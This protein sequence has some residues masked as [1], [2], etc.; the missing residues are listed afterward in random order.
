MKD[1][2]IWIIIGYFSGSIMFAYLISKI[3]RKEDIRNI[4]DDGN[5]GTANV[6]K[7]VGIPLGIIALILELA[8]GFLPVYFSAKFLDI[9]KLA[10]A[11]VLSAPVLGH[12]FP[13]YFKFKRGGK[14]IA[15]S[16]GA[17][18]GLIPDLQPALM[19]AFF[20]L[21]FSLIII[22]EPHLF[23][24]IITFLSFC[25]MFVLFGESS[26]IACGAIIISII[27]VIKHFFSYNGEKLKIRFLPAKLRK[28]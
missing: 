21:L 18:L 2:I 13:V 9:N 16:F 3:F 1:Y 25:I 14:A 23:R 28:S 11:L 24:S 19:L 26:G 10:Y 17:L 22:I 4:S 27:V 20:Y 8:K 12:A 5:P 6:F 7:Y 15:V